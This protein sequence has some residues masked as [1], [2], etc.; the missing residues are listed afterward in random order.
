MP[1][2]GELY[3]ELQAD[4][5]SLAS[6]DS[7]GQADPGEAEEDEA[8]GGSPVRTGHHHPRSPKKNCSR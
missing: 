1:F 6:Q 2:W 3:P 8:A 7:H 5:D 4:V